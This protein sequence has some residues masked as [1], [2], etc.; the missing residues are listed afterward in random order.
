V[1][2]LRCA[3]PITIGSACYEQWKPNWR[4]QL[5]V[6]FAWLLE[7]YETNTLDRIRNFTLGVILKQTSEIVGWCGLGPLEYDESETEIFFVIANKHWGR[8]LATEAARAL[9]GYAFDVLALRRV[10]TVADPLNQASTRVIGKL[11]MKPEGAVQGLGMAHCDYEGH[12]RYS[13]EASDW[14]ELARGV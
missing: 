7:C 6:T 8:G 9:L 1:R 5:A 12:V 4:L 13:M 2:R 11:R 14:A 10:V 3:I